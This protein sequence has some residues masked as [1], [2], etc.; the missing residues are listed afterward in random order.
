MGQCNSSAEPVNGFETHGGQSLK[1]ICV[2]YADE[3][4]WVAGFVDP[5]GR[6]KR[7][8]HWYVP[9]EAFRMVGVR[10]LEHDR[11]FDIARLG[12]A[13]D[14]TEA[15]GWKGLLPQGATGLIYMRPRW[16]DPA[17][18]RFSSEDPI[19]LGGGLNQYAFAEDDPV[20]AS[21]PSGAV[22]V[23]G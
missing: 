19:G 10:S 23:N 20:N 9:N 6:C 1:S 22:E 18:R 12:V 15:L 11:A 16:Y 2:G 8:R 13:W 3:F 7:W 14:G 4:G 21:D 17:L 5:C